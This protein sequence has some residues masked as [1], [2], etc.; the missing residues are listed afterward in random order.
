VF[1]FLFLRFGIGVWSSG[2]AT[3][4]VGRRHWCFFEQAVLV[5]LFVLYGDCPVCGGVWVFVGLLGTGVVR[6]CFSAS[7]GCFGLSVSF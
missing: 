6:R 5:L 4:M 3:G 1:R 7:C 2:V